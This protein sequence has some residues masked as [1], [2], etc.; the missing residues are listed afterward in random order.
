VTGVARYDDGQVNLLEPP[1][2]QDKV[3]LPALPP[4]VE[5]TVVLKWTP[6]HSGNATVRV[7][8]DLT[9][10]EPLSGPVVSEWGGG[11]LAEL[12]ECS[13]P[14]C[15]NVGTTRAD[16]I[17]PREADMG[18]DV[19]VV[20]AGPRG[21]GEPVDVRVTVTNDGPATVP[22][23]EVRLLAGVVSLLE[24]DPL[25]VTD[26]LAPGETWTRTVRMIPGFGGNLDLVGQVSA[27]ESLVRELRGLQPGGGTFDD[28][29][30][31]DRRIPVVARGLSVDVPR[32]I[33]GQPIADNG[34]LEVPVT[35]TN[36]GSE[37]LN[38]S[39][40][41]ST[42]SGIGTL[43]D[44]D[45]DPLGSVDLA[46]GEAQNGTLLLLYE[47]LPDAGRQPVTIDAV[48]K[49]GVER[50]SVDVDVP[51]R[52]DVGVRPVVERASAGKVQ[53]PITVDAT[54]NSPM[55]AQIAIDAPG[56]TPASQTVELAPGN[57]TQVTV[58]TWLDAS[59]ASTVEG[60]V[61]VRSDTLTQKAPLRI[62]QDGD[63]M[64][65]IEDARP[66]G[67]SSPH[68]WVEVSNLGSTAGSF[69]LALVQDGETLTIETVR[70]D[71]RSTE[72]VTLE[73]LPD[74]GPAQVQLTAPATDAQLNWTMDVPDLQPDI[75][76]LHA[77]LDPVSPD[78]G[79]TV[80]VQ[81]TIANEGGSAVDLR[82]GLFVDG[83]LHTV[84]AQTQTVDPGSVTSVSFEW[85]ADGGEHTLSVSADPQDR[86]DDVRASDDALAREVEIQSG[87]AAGPL[88]VDLLPLHPLAAL[89]L[90]AAAAWLRRDHS[91]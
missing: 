75:R 70:V 10:A 85:T 71:G 12:K 30:V 89:A 49:A 90:I 66:T 47:Q 20:A 35:L 36:L 11:E 39:A 52:T 64:P 88:T 27:D 3:T 63:V 61:V 87:S 15:N 23:Y 86:I 13:D 45:G 74:P 32:A 26:P 44:E 67:G 91:G 83:V 78:E 6:S 48:S 2:D 5:E 29:N 76:V 37:E 68:T 56:L 82:P 19:A 54:G 73:A 4:G 81:A 14:G 58:P 21:G 50:A 65:T 42:D 79:E 22:A 28:D 62:T 53:L 80:D 41:A 84:S 57:A 1:K 40:A 55:E 9:R 77:R 24:D 18:V 25:R 34:T 72:N 43:V 69:E 8:A 7:G 33:D 51:A 38:V 59:S 31:D 16:V 17:P 46:P 60:E